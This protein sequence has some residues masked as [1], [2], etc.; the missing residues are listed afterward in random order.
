MTDPRNGDGS[1][2]DRVHMGDNAPGAWRPT[3]YPDMQDPHCTQASQAVTPYW[4]RG[5]PFAPT[6]GSQFRPPTSGLYGTYEQL[7]AGDAC[8]AQVE[9][10]RSAGSSR[11]PARS[12]PRAG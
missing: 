10:A 9:A 1:D 8:K 7:L 5:K 11:P 6:S 2:D 4:G 12:P 3:S